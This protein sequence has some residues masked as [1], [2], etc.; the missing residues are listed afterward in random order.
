MQNCDYLLMNGGS[1]KATVVFIQSF[2]YSVTLTYRPATLTA[3]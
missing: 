3:E 1:V 2:I